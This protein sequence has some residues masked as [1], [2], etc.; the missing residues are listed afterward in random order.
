MQHKKNILCINAACPFK[1][2][3]VIINFLFGGDHLRRQKFLPSLNYAL[4]SL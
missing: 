4:P 1:I 3:I 2:I